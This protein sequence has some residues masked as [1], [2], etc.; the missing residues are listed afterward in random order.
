MYVTSNTCRLHGASDEEA[1]I[2]ALQRGLWPAVARNDYGG[3][4]DDTLARA[5]H[6]VAPGIPISRARPDDR[7]RRARCRCVRAGDVQDPPW[8]GQ[9][10]ACLFDQQPV[11]AERDC[12]ACAGD[13]LNRGAPARQAWLTGAARSRPQYILKL[14]LIAPLSSSCSRFMRSSFRPV[15]AL[16]PSS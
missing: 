4:S 13:V 7:P 5:R 2:P 8:R 10:V 1:E 15:L 3:S 9:P 12:D 6:F 16:T 14:L 11:D